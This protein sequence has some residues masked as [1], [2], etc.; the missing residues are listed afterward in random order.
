MVSAPHATTK[1]LKINMH[2]K[3]HGSCNHTKS[4]LSST[5]AMHERGEEVQL[6]MMARDSDKLPITKRL[7]NF[8]V[9]WVYLGST[10]EEKQ[11]M[12]VTR[13]NISQ[14]TATI[15]REYTARAGWYRLDVRLLNGW[16]GRTIV[17]SC[18]LQQWALLP[19]EHKKVYI[20][21]A[22]GFRADPIND[23]KCVPLIRTGPPCKEA[24]VSMKLLS[25][26][27]QVSSWLIFLLTLF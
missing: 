4:K 24:T 26:S 8:V 22:V 27:P 17:E 6:I 1:S 15:S 3:P 11:E 13:S 5:S 20:Q 23:N 25:G 19:P 2:L 16:D 7:L 10:A 14:Y 18:A 9:S 21:C 12:P